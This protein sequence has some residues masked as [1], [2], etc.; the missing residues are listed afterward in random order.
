MKMLM[1]TAI[2][3]LPIIVNAQTENPRGI[4]KMTTLTGK[5]GEV[6]APFEQY[7]ICTDSVTL[8]VTEQAAFFS[9][10]NND[11]QVFNYTGDQ[12]KFEGDRSTL[13]YDSNANQFKMKWW[14]TYTN[15]IHFPDNDWCI[16][17]Y[18]SDTY[19]EKGKVFFGA[20]TGKAEADAA[21]PL[22]GTWRF[23]GYVDELRN[24][25]KEL[26][27]LHEQ[28]PTS[29]YFN[30]FV[31]FTPKD[32]TMIV[33]GASGGV[34]K[35]EYNGKKSYKVG[36][37]TQQVKWLSKNRIALEEHIDYRTDWIIMERVT[38]GT[39]PLS[40]IASQFISRTR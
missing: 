37:K 21:N 31:I 13:I 14:S 24:A 17:K 22:T 25:K 35:I 7:K 20:L 32:W 15:H 6:K 39:T 28:Y 2:I 33:G 16:E 8:M 29:K 38:D 26:P 9:I 10:C 5:L 36:N 19:S 1:A 12:P 3:S 23:I 30:S 4:Y 18:E 40:H 11:Y 27:K 34:E